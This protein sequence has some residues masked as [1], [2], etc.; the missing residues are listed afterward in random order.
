MDK[1]QQ[2]GVTHAPDKRKSRRLHCL[3][4][5]SSQRPTLE[6]S[7]AP[8][9]RAAAGGRCFSPAWRFPDEL[10]FCAGL[11]IDHVLAAAELGDLIS[12]YGHAAVGGCGAGTRQV[13]NLGRAQLHLLVYK[14]FEDS[15]FSGAWGNMCM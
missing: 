3:L 13:S 15:L 12:T 8:S 11:A 4:L 5:G 14:A 6:I 2:L 7:G 9:G 10:R 1:Q